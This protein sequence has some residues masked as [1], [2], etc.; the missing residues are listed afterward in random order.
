MR[1][2]CTQMRMMTVTQAYLD[3]NATAPLRPEA[4]AAMMAALAVTGNPSSVHADGRAAR[5]L[6]EAAREQVAALV[7][8][9]LA[10]RGVHF[11]RHRGQ[12]AG[13]VACARRDAGLVSAIEHPSVRSG[14]GLPQPRTFR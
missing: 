2:P 11:G 1:H 5:R 12:H 10:G 8:A 14:G 3:W 13:A 9:E 7:G 4:Q 6:V